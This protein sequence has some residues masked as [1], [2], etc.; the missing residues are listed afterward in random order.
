MEQPYFFGNYFSLTFIGGSLVVGFTFHPK[1]FGPVVGPM[2]AICFSVN[3]DGV[4]FL[5]GGQ[6]QMR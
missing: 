1:I 4:V 3:V 6:H 2:N 5:L